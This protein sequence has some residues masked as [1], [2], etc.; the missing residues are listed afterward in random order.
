MAKTDLLPL[1]EHLYVNEQCSLAEIAKRLDVAE[2]T[3]RNWKDKARREGG[4]WELKRQNLL[5][6]RQSFH[7]ELYDL[8]RDIASSIR[9]DIKAKREV[10]P[11]RMSF[12]ARLLPQLV[13]VKEYEAVAREKDAPSGGGKPEDVVELIRGVLVGSGS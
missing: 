2:R 10:S 7:E 1:A 9:E 11:S 12:L 4:D 6:S 8:A 5:A 13:H 3:I